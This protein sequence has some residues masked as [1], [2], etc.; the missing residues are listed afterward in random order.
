M[1]RL[2]AIGLSLAFVTG[3]AACGGGGD[4]GQQQGSATGQEAARQQPRISVSDST[5]VSFI[6]ASL[7][8]ETFRQEMRSRMQEASGQEGRKVRK[9]LMQERDSIIEAAGLSGPAR[10]DTIME[11]IKTNERLRKRYMSLRDSIESSP[12][13]GDTAS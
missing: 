6:D 7:E 11:A 12:A 13:S 2:L 5:L 3:A 10:Y 1:K 8:L 9:K 4:A